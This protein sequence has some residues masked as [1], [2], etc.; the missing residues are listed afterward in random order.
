ML[1][2]L[3]GIIALVNDDSDM[4]GNFKYKHLSGEKI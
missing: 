1:E 3:P 4:P 2:M